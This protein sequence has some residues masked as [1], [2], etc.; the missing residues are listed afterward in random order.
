MLPELA[1]PRRLRVA[2]LRIAPP[3]P[4]VW[5]GLRRMR[6][7]LPVDE[8]WCEQRRWTS[9]GN[10]ELPA[11]DLPCRRFTTQIVHRRRP[12][13]VGVYLGQRWKIAGAGLHDEATQGGMNHAVEL[14][15]QWVAPLY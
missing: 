6:R 1:Q 11:Q 7:I 15:A 13:L 12:P 9:V 2:R 10:H 4:G 3:T 14:V 8:K 5:Q